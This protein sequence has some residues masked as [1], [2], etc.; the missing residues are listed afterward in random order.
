MLHHKLREIRMF[1]RCV[2]NKEVMRKQYDPKKL[3]ILSLQAYYIN[4]LSQIS[5]LGHET[6]ARM[7][8]TL[9]DI[10][11]RATRYVFST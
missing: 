10:S 4:F 8:C 1:K 3:M 6:T 7:H 9:V 11:S 2:K 5:V